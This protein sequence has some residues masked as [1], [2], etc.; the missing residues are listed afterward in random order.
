MNDNEMKNE[1]KEKK[2]L[3]E[4]GSCCNSG[5]KW[6]WI[7]IVLVVVVLI[8]KNNKKSKEDKT[9]LDT[10]SS[11]AVV[12]DSVSAVQV[13]KKLPKLIDMGADKCV[14]C[15]MMAPILEELEKEYATAQPSGLVR[16][17]RSCGAW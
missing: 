12:T 11:S 10:R 17:D 14:P 1:Q 6:L 2:P 9:P 3:D 8:A 7:I 16:E 15:K 4:C 13:E 5:W